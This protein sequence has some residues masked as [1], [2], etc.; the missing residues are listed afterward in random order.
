[1][2]RLFYSRDLDSL[3]RKYQYARQESKDKKKCSRKCRTIEHAIVCAT[4]QRSLISPI[5]VG[6]GVHLHRKYASKTLL[7]IL[8]NLGICTSYSEAV[9]Y[10]SSAT[11]NSAA[12]IDGMRM[13][14]A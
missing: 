13:P 2:Q 4:R 9:R 12:I 1:M 3:H 5:Q 6:L 7:D 8:C 10:K 11:Q 14:N